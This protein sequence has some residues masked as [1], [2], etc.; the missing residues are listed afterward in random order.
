MSTLTKLLKIPEQNCV[1][2][3]FSLLKALEVPA[4]ATTVKA[5]L[6]THPEYPTLLSVSDILHGLQVRNITVKAQKERLSELP[7]PFLAQVSVDGKDYFTTVTAMDADK[8]TCTDVISGKTNRITTAKFKE[9]WTEVALLAEKG[10]RSGERDYEKNRKKEKIGHGALVLLGVI[11]LA[12]WLQTGAY[13]ILNNGIS[14]LFP[15]LL[16]TLLLAGTAVALI[17]LSH[18][19]DAHNPLMEKACRASA[20]VNCDAV[21]NSEAAK[22]GGYFSWSEAGFAYFSGGLLVA[23][24]SGM[25]PGVMSVLAWLNLLAIP[26]VFFSVY[27]QWKVVKQWCVLCLVTQGILVLGLGVSVAGNL[28]NT[29]ALQTLTIPAIVQ[30]TLLAL[31]PI[32]A[33]LLIKPYLLLPRELSSTKYSLARLKHDPEVFSSML[34]NQR[35]LAGEELPQGLGVVLGNPDS[36]RKIIKIC[37]LFCGPCSGSHPDL[38]D[39]LDSN[40]DVQL[41]IVFAVNNEKDEERVAPV[42]H[43]LAIAATRPQEVLKEALHDWYSANKKD[44]AS[45]AAKYPM[46]GELAQQNDHVQKLHSW[47]MISN[48]H[49]TPTFFYKN[50]ELPGSFNIRDLKYLLTTEAI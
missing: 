31:L 24:F 33:W 21:L 4:T 49:A 22:L 9:M 1:D 44:Y 36:D 14:G 42:R 20:T 25:H 17:L 13:S 43:L 3:V 46:N 26:Y 16:L 38:E 18:E 8:V 19:T 41:Q 45:F 6:T 28:F 23:L 5:E 37:N 34:A 2:A 10:E 7:V 40:E 15:F 48:I 32:V 12:L 50:Q 39:I 35:I 47:Y 29:E 27:Y 30:W 11:I